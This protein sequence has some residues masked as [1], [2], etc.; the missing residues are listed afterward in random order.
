M[1]APPTAKPLTVKEFDRAVS[2]VCG[3]CSASCAYIAYLKGRELIDLYGHPHDPNGIG[4]FCTK[5]II[6][7]Q[8][9]PK[10]PLRI[11]KPLLR[12]GDT[13]KEISWEEAEKLLRESLKGKVAFFFDR[14]SGVEEYLIAK[15][16]TEDVFTDSLYLPFKSSSVR[17]Q[18]WAE[19][20]A[21]LIFEA[22]PT[23]SEVMLTRWIVDAFERDAYILAVG[24]RFT[25]VFQKATDKVLTTPDETVKILESIAEGEY[26]EKVIKLLELLGEETQV[27]V[28]DTLLRSPFKNRVLNAVKKIRERFGTDYSFVGNIT[29]FE[30]KGLKEFLER[31]GE[32]ETLVLFGNPFIYLK[33]TSVIEGKTIINFAYFPTITANYSSLVIPRTTFAEREFINRGAGFLA[34][35]PQVLENEFPQSHELLSEVTGVSPKVEEFLKDF[36]VSLEDLKTAEGGIL[37]NQKD[38]KEFSFEPEEEFSAEYWLLCDNTLTEDLGHWNPWTHALEREQFAYVNERTKGELG[39]ERE[40]EIKGV[41]LRLKVNNNIADRVVFVP[42]SFEEFQ[43]FEP[44]VRVGRLMKKP[45]YRL[46]EFP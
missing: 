34:Y 20:R 22:E 16:I 44:G 8:E 10:N 3:G 18:S 45:Y 32:F 40:I 30:T 33:D 4:S 28:G 15:E 37:I 1:P 31:I 23:F 46:E 7:V 42:N 41:K 9:L 21:I 19:K 36:G 27:I 6:Y 39:V 25:T 5:G 2:G 38:I 24:S 13:F 17:P 43:P 14:F 35:S 26:E 12:D 29:P 11:R